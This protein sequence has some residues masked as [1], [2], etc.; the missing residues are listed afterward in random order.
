MKIKKM[1]LLM[2]SVCTIAFPA[3]VS[4]QSIFPAASV[5]KTSSGIQPYGNH[6]GYKYMTIAGKRFKRL[7]SYT[8]NR[9]EDP[10]WTPA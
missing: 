1:F 4:A 9:W 6:T 10:A 3:T 5:E 8:Y 2:F 7:W